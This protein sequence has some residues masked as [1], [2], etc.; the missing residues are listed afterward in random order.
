M[1]ALNYRM[2][3]DP[4]SP[5]LFT[6]QK[7]ADRTDLMQRVGALA[8]STM[9]K[10]LSQNRSKES[11]VATGRL[12]AS[13]SAVAPGSGIAGAHFRVGPDAVD[14]GSNLK[15][16]NQADKGGTISPRNGKALAVPVDAKVARAGKWPRDFPRDALGY[17]PAPRAPK[18]FAVLVDR[19]GKSGFGRGKLL[20]ALV[21]SISQPGLRFAGWDLAMIRTIEQQIYP[22]WLSGLRGDIA[23]VD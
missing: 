4:S 7:L 19:D 17:I 12:A 10:R 1:T 8:T 2:K 13:L 3:I 18:A 14:V 11:E 20:F 23:G 22:Q 16:A 9:V 5:F 6:R 15:Y 21:R